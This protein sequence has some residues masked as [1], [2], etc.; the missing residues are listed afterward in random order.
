VW[1]RDKYRAPNVEIRN[2]RTLGHIQGNNYVNDRFRMRQTYLCILRMVERARCSSKDVHLN[3]EILTFVLALVI[4]NTLLIFGKDRIA[5][6]ESVVA[7]FEAQRGLT[8]VT[9]ASIE[10]NSTN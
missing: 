3:V 10:E 4:S 1:V 7:S 9:V 6:K 2:Y 5:T 8:C